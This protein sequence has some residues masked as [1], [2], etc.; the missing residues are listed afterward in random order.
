MEIFVAEIVQPY[1]NGNQIGKSAI[2]LDSARCHNTKSVKEKLDQ[3]SIKKISVPPR[4]TNLFQP[5]DVCWFRPL[6]Q[7]YHR[8][9]NDWFLVNEYKIIQNF[10]F[11]KTA[12]IDIVKNFHVLRNF[13]FDSFY[14][15]MKSFNIDFLLFC[16]KNYSKF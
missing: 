10:N 2:L 8:L 12:K 7:N 1:M 16:E 11:H 9:W 14:L 6:K 15:I 5:A 3:L 13:Y 4:M